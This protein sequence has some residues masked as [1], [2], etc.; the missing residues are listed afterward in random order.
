MHAPAVHA[1]CDGEALTA[2]DLAAM[3][4][5]ARSIGAT[6]YIHLD[7]VLAIAREDVPALLAEVRRLREC[8]PAT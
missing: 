2:R 8:G 7:T 5:R 6:N 1:T 4:E 3:E